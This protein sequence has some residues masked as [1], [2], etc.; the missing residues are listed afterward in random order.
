MRHSNKL[1]KEYSA[2]LT[3]SSQNTN[4]IKRLE[5]EL[6]Q[7]KDKV[8][9][10][11]MNSFII[12]IYVNKFSKLKN[13]SFNTSLSN[14][15]SFKPAILS[16][17]KSKVSLSSSSFRVSLTLSLSILLNGSRSTI[18][19]ESSYSLGLLSPGIIVFLGLPVL[20]KAKI[21]L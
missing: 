11:K 4:T 1:L 21:G 18:P 8:C 14:S 20:T 15:S 9:L 3:G 10:F 12:Q 7:L 2:A 16:L 6:V 17:S 13:E 5:D 19:A